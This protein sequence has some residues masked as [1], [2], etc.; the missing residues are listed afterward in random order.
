[1]SQQGTWGVQI[2]L[3]LGQ[4]PHG[5]TGAPTESSNSELLHL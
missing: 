2:P 3:R 4:V 5:D 1:M